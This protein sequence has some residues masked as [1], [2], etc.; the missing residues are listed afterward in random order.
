ML[1]SYLL[2]TRSDR[3]GWPAS[4]GLPKFSGLTWR[5]LLQELPVATIPTAILYGRFLNTSTTAVGVILLL[6]H[7]ER[8]P[9]TRGRGDRDRGGATESQYKVVENLLDFK[10]PDL[11]IAPNGKRD[12]SLG[13][14]NLH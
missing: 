7:F 2:Q 9:I 6:F 5:L 14:E 1:R 10:Q 13:G 8:A 11:A 12:S 4:H 3:T